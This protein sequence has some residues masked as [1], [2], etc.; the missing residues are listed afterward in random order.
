MVF[1]TQVL[2]L[3]PLHYLEYL[4]PQLCS[5]LGL[6]K[7]IPIVQGFAHCHFLY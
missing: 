6:L 3:V 5:N 7:P 2:F 1:V 4:W